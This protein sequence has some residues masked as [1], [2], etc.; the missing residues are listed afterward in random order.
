MPGEAGC[1][2]CPVGKTAP[3]FRSERT[4]APYR[5]ARATR[6]SQSGSP[7]PRRPSRNSGAAGPAEQVQRGPDRVRVRPRRARRGVPAGLGQRQRVRQRLLLHGHVQADVDRRGRCRH[8][9]LMRLGER[10]QCRRYRGGLVVPLGVGPDQRALIGGGVD[11][12]DPG[13]PPGRVDGA[14]SPDDQHRDPV[15][16]GVVDGHG[17]VHQA[18]VGVHRHGERAPG[19]LGVA[20]R[21]RHRVLLV[22]ADEHLRVPVAVV[23][24]QAVV[25]PAIARAGN[26]RHV[27]Q[28]E[29]AQQAGERVAA[30]SGRDVAALEAFGIFRP[31]AAPPHRCCATEDM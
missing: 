21:E 9:D 8:R 6:R 17:R 31:H 10:V 4:R 26:Q 27:R 16:P 29:A 22:Q 23:V 13:P 11:P 20:V 30:P 3:F 7:R 18:H 14:G 5:S 12:V 28:A 24:D 1:S 19:H 15:A 25:Q 2:R